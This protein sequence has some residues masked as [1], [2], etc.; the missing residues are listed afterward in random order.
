MVIK[1]EQ[2]EMALAE[3]RSRIM[4]SARSM[5][6]TRLGLGNSIECQITIQ[7]KHS[8]EIDFAK[9]LESVNLYIASV[10]ETVK[11]FEEVSD[12]VY[13][14][15]AKLYSERDIDIHVINNNTGIAF[16]KE[17]RTHKPLQQLAI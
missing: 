13:E 10:G 2:R 7:H 16:V 11:N 17:Y 5:Y 14:H 1:M 12:G 6:V 8:E 4:N 9:V 3:Q 15:I